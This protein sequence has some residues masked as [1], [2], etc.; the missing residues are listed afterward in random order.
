M[1]WPMKKGIKV[2]LY[3]VVLAIAISSVS[4]LLNVGDYKTPYNTT[5]KLQGFFAEPDDT[6]DVVFIG[7]STSFMGINPSLL[8]REY[9]IPSYDF[10]SAGQFAQLAQLF[11]KETIRQQHPQVI[12][13]DI[14][15]LRHDDDYAP[16]ARN[17]RALTEFPFSLDKLRTIFEYTPQEEWASHLLPL[18][19]YHSVLKADFRNVRPVQQDIYLGYTPYFGNLNKKISLTEN[20]D[21]TETTA[22]N[23]NAEKALREIIAVCKENGVELLLYSTPMKL[24][25]TERMRYNEVGRIAEEESVLFLDLNTREWLEENNY[26]TKTDASNGHKHPNWRGAEKITRA[27]GDFLVENTGVTD[28]RGEEAYAHWD[29]KT[30]PYYH[31]KAVYLAGEALKGVKQLD[32]YMAALPGVQA[33][34]LCTVV[35]VMDEG[36]KF[37]TEAADASL[38]SMGAVEPLK[39][40]FRAGYLLV[41]VDGECVYSGIS[42]ENA[43]VFDSAALSREDVNVQACSAGY[44]VIN[45]TE[46]EEDIE[47]NTVILDGEKITAK[48]GINVFVYDYVN[49]EIVDQARFDT[50]TTTERSAK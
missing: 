21:L 27:L 2:V 17:Y 9:G 46:N 23:A 36:S 32:E 7:A 16:S 10:C 13:L 3:F 5:T 12:A 15:G 14:G 30:K 1:D 40:Q 50:Y 45:G 20:V 42:A 48:R 44:D 11:V 8:W 37:M 35:M 39:E 19:K 22:L 41:L 34:G 25:D 26:Q 38:M 33:E 49:G 47:Y 18:I 29:D 31:E 28:R 4:T 43:L 6:L 24:T